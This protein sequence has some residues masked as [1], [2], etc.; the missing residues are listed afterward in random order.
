LLAPKKDRRIARLIE[1]EILPS[2][3]PTILIRTTPKG[4]LLAQ[5]L[6]F[7]VKSPKQKCEQGPNCSSPARHL[8][9]REDGV[10]WCQA[11]SFQRLF[12]K[13]EMKFVWLYVGAL[14]HTC[15]ISVGAI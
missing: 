15:T 14:K 7:S 1:R 2:V 5:G 11:P 9:L 10:S 13:M 6:Q 8:G 12:I 4:G 3:K